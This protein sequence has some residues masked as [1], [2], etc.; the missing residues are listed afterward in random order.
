VP[1]KLQ[2]APSDLK[3]IL[4][5]IRNDVAD[6]PQIQSATAH[7][8]SLDLSN[9]SAPELKMPVNASS[10]PIVHARRAEEAVVP[11][12]ENHAPDSAALNIAPSAANVPR[13]KLQ[14]TAST[15]RLAP[16]S[17]SQAETAAAPEIS[18]GPGQ[19]S[20]S[21]SAGD[22]SLRRLI[23]LSTTPA[24]P[25]QNVQVPTGN[26]AARISISPG[27]KTA[28]GSTKPGA[29][30]KGA[31]GPPGVYVSSTQ[32]GAASPVSGNGA[33]SSGG[34]TPSASALGITHSTKPALPDANSTTSPNRGKRDFSALG[35]DI[36]PEKILGGKRIYTAYVNLP[37]L[38]S[39]KGSWI[40]NFAELEPSGSPTHVHTDLAAPIVTRTV[41]PKY[42]TSLIKQHIEGEVILYAI[43][44]QS[45]EVDSIQVVKKLDPQ[46][47]RNAIEAV[48]AW[49]FAPASRNG[50]PVAVEA[51][52]HI[53]FNAP[54]P[55]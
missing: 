2:I 11:E 4:R 41:D 7:P 45:G 3:P 27:S 34:L 46:L 49:K 19:A 21:P 16:R 29:G 52:I 33:A 12:I 51:V 30:G 39:A 5:N 14:V 35:D 15:A 31:V 1:P 37:N 43:I 53:P 17:N 9:Q 44:R 18:N 24:P 20:G 26:L 47:D 55:K 48:S 38:T 32:P 6:A 50:E 23:A 42:P 40:L 10:A 8:N 54:A 28:N 36:T 22:A 13:P 25:A